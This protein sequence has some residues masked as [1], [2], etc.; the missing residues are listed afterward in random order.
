MKKITSFTLLLF[1][2]FFLTSCEKQDN[3]QKN[4]STVIDNAY[5]LNNESKI[6]EQ[7]E[8]YNKQLLKDFDIDFQVITTMS[9]EDINLFSNKNFN[10]LQKTSRSKSGKAILLVINTMKDDVRLEVSKA[11]EPIYTD[12]FIYYIQRKGFVPYFRSFE[13]ANG[14]YAASELIRDRAHE[15]NE[16]KEWMPPMMSESEGAGAKAKANI[17]IK[18]KDAKKGPMVKS[19]HGDNPKQ[20][21]KIYFN[22]IKNHNKN[23]N[24]DIYTEETKNFFKK[25]ITTE[26]NQ[27]HEYNLMTKCTHTTLV[28]DETNEYAVILYPLKETNCSPY[29]FRKE[30]G[31]WKLDIS[32][33][34][35]LILFNHK[36]QWHFNLQCK[37][38]TPHR[39]TRIY[40]ENFI[41]EKI[42][43]LLNPYKFAFINFYFD[44][45]GFP[46]N[47][48]GKK[49]RFGIMFNE[50]FNK[51]KIYI[52]TYI[53]NIYHGSLAHKAG[54]QSG[55]KI[56]QW[57]GKTIQKGDKK[58][59]SKSMKNIAQGSILHLLVLKRTNTFKKIEIVA[60]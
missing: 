40:A 30:D 18:D 43:S 38:N 25:W 50:Y 44:K 42:N 3:S 11:L 48:W 2:I 37:D 17:G 47:F 39:Y 26:I 55:D 58:F 16:G 8:A 36:M 32:S 14:I 1:L 27:D 4:Y 41:P 57:E 31:A 7:F 13:I 12:S 34:N 23:P 51:N 52:G 5:V 33:M 60:P 56:V 19:N 22:A 21:L 59:I 9:D 29:F 10:T 15:A 28:Y 20:V 35:K 53:N 54:L 49:P 24:L 46:F 6:I 45:N